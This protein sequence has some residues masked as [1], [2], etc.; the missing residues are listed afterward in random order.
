MYLHDIVRVFVIIALRSCFS[1]SFAYGPVESIGNG[2]ENYDYP[3][4]EKKSLD[5]GVPEAEHVCPTTIMKRHKPAFGHMG[6]GSF[7]EVQ[8]D[9]EHSFVAT[10]VECTNGHHRPPCHGINTVIKFVLGL[11]PEISRCGQRN[12]FWKGERKVVQILIPIACQCRL[13]RKLQPFT[14]RLFTFLN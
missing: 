13:I 7:V 4:I 12:D 14:R 10:F 3:A 6:N 1:S 8:Q 5:L 11:L 2:M 9:S